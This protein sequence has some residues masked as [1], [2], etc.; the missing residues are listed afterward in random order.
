[1]PAD[2]MIREYFSLAAYEVDAEAL[3]PVGWCPISMSTTLS[4][5]SSGMSR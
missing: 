3:M 5:N 1:M 2:S 4:R